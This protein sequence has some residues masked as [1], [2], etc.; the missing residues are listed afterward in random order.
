MDKDGVPRS[1]NNISISRGPS[2]FCAH[3]LPDLGRMMP[4]AS[5]SNVL[6]LHTYFAFALIMYLHREH[7]IQYN[8]HPQKNYIA[9]ILVHIDDL[10][11]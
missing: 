3:S 5:K 11:H 10:K 7:P 4:S 2:E 1:E 8:P 6:F 9:P